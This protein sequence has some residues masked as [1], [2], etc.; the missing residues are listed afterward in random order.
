MKRCNVCGQ[1]RSKQYQRNLERDIMFLN[2]R[3]EY[4]EGKEFYDGII[5]DYKKIKREKE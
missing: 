2:K 4:L 1:F 3:I 5:K